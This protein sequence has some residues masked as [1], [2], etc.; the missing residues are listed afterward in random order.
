MKFL[1]TGN[2]FYTVDFKTALMDGLAPDR[3]LFFPCEIPKLS[4]AFFDALPDLSNSEIAYQAILPYLV[5]EVSESDLYAIVEDTLNFD[6]PVVPIHDNIHTL[7][8]FHGPTKAFK[9]VGARF[10]SRMMSY[11]NKDSDKKIKI[12]VATSGDTGSAVANGFYGVDGVE[13]VILF[14]KGKVSKY[15]EHQM[16]SLGKNITALEIDGVFDD[17]Q[18]IV[19]SAFVDPDLRDMNLSS[20]NSINLGRLLPQMFYYF[21][22]CKDF[23]KTGKE[24]VF[25]VPSGNFGNLTA[26]I[27]AKEM[28]LQIHSFVAATNTNDTFHQYVLNG[29]YQAKPSV[30]T[31]SNAMDVGAPSNFERMMHIYKEDH[32]A[33]TNHIYSDSVSDMA[34]LEKIKTCHEKNNYI[35]DPHGAVGLIALERFLRKDQIGIFLE[36]AHPYKFESVVSKAIDNFKAPVVDLSNAHKISMSRSYDEFKSFLMASK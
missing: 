34:T 18:D 13:V 23:V 27:I 26:G 25:S 22:A 17:C 30:E 1:S 10:M 14:P 6:L 28:G 31:Y 7:E 35:L 32:D 29:I 15:Q 5:D 3:S 33:I 9:D 36:T 11:F 21:T 8:L 20:A 4:S 12:L 2:S 16:T 24:I 19:K